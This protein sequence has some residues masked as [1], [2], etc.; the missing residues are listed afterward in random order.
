MDWKSSAH[1]LLTHLIVGD[2]S[3]C[4][5]VV[6]NSL[7]YR[8]SWK[9]WSFLTRLCIHTSQVW[10]AGN[11]ASCGQHYTGDITV[12]T[13]YTWLLLKSSSLEHA[14][15]FTTCFFLFYPAWS[16]CVVR[17]RN[18]EVRSKRALLIPSLQTGNSSFQRQLFTHPLGSS[19]RPK[20]L[21]RWLL[22]M[23]PPISL[24]EGFPVIQLRWSI[25]CNVLIAVNLEE[26][27]SDV[28]AELW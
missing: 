4:N 19:A 6:A 2:I 26:E 3:A 1:V 12:T 24:S 9:P 5:I 22:S 15:T 18:T 8:L 13:V 28:I 10:V 25:L 14:I 20:P 11:M 17:D 23:L 21:G 7:H 27:W 16:F